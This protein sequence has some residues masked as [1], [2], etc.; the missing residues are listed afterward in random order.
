M[1]KTI[2]ILFLLSF[3]LPFSN[4]PTLAQEKCCLQA[5]C[6]CTQETCCREKQC[7]CKGDCCKDNACNCKRGC[8]CAKKVD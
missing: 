1:K 3:L 2:V 5:K 7:A 8:S 6:Q 4:T